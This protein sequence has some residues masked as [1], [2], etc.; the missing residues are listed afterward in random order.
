MV[1]SIK[2][3]QETF[4]SKLERERKDRGRASRNKPRSLRQVLLVFVVKPQ[5]KLRLRRNEKR[6]DK[7]SKENP[8]EDPFEV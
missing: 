6:F 3:K 2:T 5:R 7:Y 1:T 8:K 4:R